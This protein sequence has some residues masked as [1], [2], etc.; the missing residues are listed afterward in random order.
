MREFSVPASVRVGDDDTLSDT[1]FALGT[2]TVTC[3]TT[4]AA[5]NKGTNSFTVEVVDTTAPEVHA[6]A[7]LV[8]GNTSPTGASNVVYTGAAATDVVSGDLPVTCTQA[9]GS[10]FPALTRRSGCSVSRCSGG[11]RWVITPHSSVRP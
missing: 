11:S 8:V 10:T 5:G 1:V 7:N 2:T 9:S 4:D 3:T 6:P